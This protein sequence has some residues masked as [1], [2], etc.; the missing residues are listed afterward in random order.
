MN[1]RHAVALLLLGFGS[2]FVLFGSIIAGI[3]VV[4]I[5]NAEN[6]IAFKVSLGFAACGGMVLLGGGVCL[7][8]GVRLYQRSAH[9]LEEVRDNQ[10]RLTGRRLPILSP[11]MITLFL[12][13]TGALAWFLTEYGFQWDNPE[14]RKVYLGWVALALAFLAA[15][16][17]A[18][19][20]WLRGSRGNSKTSPSAKGQTRRCPPD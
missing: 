18:V 13:L 11:I 17:R 10:G 6:A 4:H 5:P 8:Y 2:V 19:L 9:R 16:W 14:A 3:G 7:W 1:L 20:R 12:M 15:C